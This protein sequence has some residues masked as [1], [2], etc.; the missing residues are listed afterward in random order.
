MDMTYSDM[1]MLLQK[2]P[3]AK[4]YFESLPLQVQAQLSA[5]PKKV[6]RLSD[7]KGHMQGPPRHWC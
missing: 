1:Y 5:D 4:K 6:R 3:E 2:E 7:L